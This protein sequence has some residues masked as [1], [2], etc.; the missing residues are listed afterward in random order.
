MSN[1]ERRVDDAV[2]RAAL[3]V[4]ESLAIALVECGMVAKQEIICAL[5]DAASAHRNAAEEGLDQD[6][7]AFAAAVIERMIRTLNAAHDN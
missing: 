6:V 5:E 7:N 2:A 3:S 4:G 1:T